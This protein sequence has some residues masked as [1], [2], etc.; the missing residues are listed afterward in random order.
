MDSRQMNK[1]SIILVT[2]IVSGMIICACSHHP[3]GTPAKEYEFLTGECLVSPELTLAH[4]ELDSDGYFHFGFRL[5][6]SNVHSKE[7]DY[8]PYPYYHT[9]DNNLF[10]SFGS[11]SKMVEEEY[12]AIMNKLVAGLGNQGS[13]FSIVTILYSGGI[14]FTADKPFAGHDA[15]DE[16]SPYLHEIISPFNKEDKAG[17]YLDIPLDYDYLM[18]K[19]FGIKI[20]FDSSNVSKDDITFSIRIPVTVVNY[21]HWINDRITNPDAAVP[22]RKEELRC[23]FTIRM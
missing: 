14:S 13:H 6:L 12:N 4:T 17:S 19:G 5:D 20:P 2:V 7:S 1:Y 16:L 15:Y 22:F 10:S 9:P 8:S 18:E 3:W 11:N 21:L 23:T